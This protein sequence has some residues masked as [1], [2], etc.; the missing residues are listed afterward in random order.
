MFAE[1]AQLLLIFSF[2]LCVFYGLK[3]FWISF[4]SND[5]LFLNQ[6][7]QSV[8][9]TSIFIGLLLFTC[10]LLLMQL[11][12]VSDFSVLNVAENSNALLPIEYKIA[13]TWGSHEG[14]FLLW[15]VMLS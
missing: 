15:I 7:R 2:L 12:I 14:S 8:S 1:I 6:T 13:A 11:F 4:N 9:R 5:E 3:G 10:F